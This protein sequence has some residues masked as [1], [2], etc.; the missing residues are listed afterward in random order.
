MNRDLSAKTPARP[1]YVRYGVLAFACTLAMITYLDRATIGVTQGSMQEAYGF[2]SVADLKWAPFAFS[3]AYA[4]F[5]VPTGWL[6]DVFG[7][8]RTLLRIVLWWSFFTALIG[9][10]GFRIGGF[11][12]L[13]FAGLV[14]VN[15]LFGVGEAGAFPNITRA[16]HNWFPAQERGLAQG[17]VW[18][19]GRL[20]GGLTALIWM[21]LVVRTGLHWRAAFWLFGGLG[22]VWGVLFF[23]WFRNRPEEKESVG[24]EELALIRSG[25]GHESDRAHGAFPWRMLRSPTLWCLCVMYFC[26]SYAWYFNIYYLPS[27]LKQQYGVADDSTVGQ[28]YKG[29]P[30][31]LGAGACL[32]GGFLTDRYVR[33]TGDRRWGRRLFG[34]LGHGLCIPCCLACVV[35]PTAF[36]F[37]LAIGLSGFFNDLAMGPAWAACQDVGKKHAAIVAGCMNMVGNLGGAASAWLT[38]ALLERTHIPYAVLHGLDPAAL[39]TA[40]LKAAELLGYHINFFIC[41]GLYVVAL[42]LW[43]GIDATKPVLPE[44]VDAA[45]VGTG[46]PAGD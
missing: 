28:L 31:I 12:L 23:L 40:D 20:M 33:R 11:M 34:M 26:M 22:V 39:G 27:F 8:R 6:G 5:E 41:A 45:A 36:T 37:A 21:L 43:L 15:F 9:L 35:A 46:V 42:L 38:G 25:V 16:L 17:F 24:P 19:S 44:D 13:P 32:L 3:L 30:L 1:T 18:M 7:P 14:A 10:A 29:A 2:S 4:L